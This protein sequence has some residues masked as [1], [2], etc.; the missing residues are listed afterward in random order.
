[1]HWLAVFLFAS[2]IAVKH[3]QTPL[4]GGCDA[5][6]ETVAALPAGSP[7]E[8]RFAMTGPA[9]TCYKVSASVNGK[10]VQGYLPA[11][12]LSGLEEFEKA[13]QSAP[14]IEVSREA[15]QV[16]ASPDAAGAPDQLLEKAS[17]LLQQH[18]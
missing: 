4:R 10:P 7:I 9:E 1:M 14:A 12:A 11:S 5:H 16:I 3:D 8:I 2:G 17:A 6:E 15:Q 18:Q 13:R